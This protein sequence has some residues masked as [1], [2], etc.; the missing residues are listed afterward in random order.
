MD[1]DKYNVDLIKPTEVLGKTDIIDIVTL[2]G[3]RT[4]FYCDNQ[5]KKFWIVHNGFEEKP[6]KEGY[7]LGGIYFNEELIEVHSEKEKQVIEILSK[8]KAPKE[9][10]SKYDEELDTNHGKMTEELVEFIIDFLESEKYSAFA[11]KTGRLR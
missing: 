9:W 3:G 8:M 1:L 4:S 10:Y 6:Y 2:S 11:K 5:G 7:W